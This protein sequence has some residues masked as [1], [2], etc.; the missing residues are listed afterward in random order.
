ML[1]MKAGRNRGAR[2]HCLCPDLDSGLSSLGDGTRQG[3]E[4]G[5]DFWGDPMRFWGPDMSMQAVQND[6]L[7]CA[8]R[9]GSRGDLGD[10]L[11]AQ[12]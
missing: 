11:Q 8:L 2:R 5:R 9:G 1:E 3:L 7:L 10:A 4:V 12:M 6:L